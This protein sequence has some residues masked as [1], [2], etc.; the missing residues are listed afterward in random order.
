M[1]PLVWLIDYLILGD[2][3]ATR[4]EVG[5]AF[6]PQICGYN[7]MHWSPMLTDHDHDVATGLHS[8]NLRALEDKLRHYLRVAPFG[9][10]GLIAICQGEKYVHR[11]DLLDN[12]LFHSSYITSRD[13]IR[14][15]MASSLYID[16]LIQELLVRSS[17]NVSI[18]PWITSYFNK[19]RWLEGLM[20]PHSQQRS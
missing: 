20:Q 15:I 13:H 16:I 4:R 5:I 18:N 17:C 2:D 12:K 19:I 7:F 9:D 14:P 6:A 1:Q 11:L 3:D 8:N 10:F